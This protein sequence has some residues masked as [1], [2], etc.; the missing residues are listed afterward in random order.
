MI[1][2]PVG[3]PSLLVQLQGA[4]AGTGA[5]SCG[6]GAGAGGARSFF[7]AG[8]G[9]AGLAGRSHGR[10][11]NWLTG[12]A[13]TLT[14]SIRTTAGEKPARFA[15]RSMPRPASARPRKNPSQARGRLPRERR[16]AAGG[17]TEAG[18]VGGVGRVP[19]RRGAAGA[20]G[21]VGTGGVGG[22]GGAGGD[23]DVGGAG[24]LG[25]RG[26]RGG[27]VPPTA[28]P[29]ESGAEPAGGFPALAR[30]CATIAARCAAVAMVYSSFMRY[31]SA[32]SFSSFSVASNRELA[33]LQA[34]SAEGLS[35]TY[36]T[37]SV[38]AFSAFSSQIFKID[39]Q[40]IL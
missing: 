17:A 20:G 2:G 36:T 37:A 1:G 4:G 16:D 10:S 23:G 14:F 9:F 25:G 27:F 18:G 7:G 15:M 26:R 3:P 31:Q 32:C 13:T 5:G 6:L 8:A 28:D 29:P 30:S 11:P 39:K 40:P 33:S 19:R 12:G 22:T 34:E 24:G 38:W 35:T 21:G